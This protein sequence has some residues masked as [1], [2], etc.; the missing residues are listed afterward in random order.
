MRLLLTLLIVNRSG[1]NSENRIAIVA[2]VGG[3]KF[4]G[5]KMYVDKVDNSAQFQKLPWGCIS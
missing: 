5:G 1:S 3:E 2:R 4:N